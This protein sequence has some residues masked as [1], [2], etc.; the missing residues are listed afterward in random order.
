[1][2]GLVTMSLGD[3]FM[4]YRTMMRLSKKKLSEMSGVSVDIIS[5][6]ENNES[7]TT[8]NIVMLASALGVAV[9][10]S[11]I[12]SPAVPSKRAMPA[13]PVVRREEYIEISTH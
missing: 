2:V 6:I 10:L 1:M 12:P 5:R 9:T 7:A 8:D 4:K 3:Q 11:F 13:S